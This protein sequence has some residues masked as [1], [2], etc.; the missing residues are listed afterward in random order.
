MDE[1]QY[2]IRGGVDGRERLRI[3][4]RVLAPTTRGLLERVGLGPGM[5][6]LDAGC[7]GGDVT[8]EMARMVGAAGRV[9]GIDGD[10]AKIALARAEAA[11]MSLPGLSFAV[12]TIGADCAASQLDLVYSRFVLTHLREPAAAL[13]WMVQRLRPGGLV[14]LEDIDFRGHFCHPPSDAFT[15]YV[16][17]YARVVRAHGADPDIGPRLPGLLREA[18]CGALGMHVVQPAAFAGELKL[19]AAIT[20]ENIADAVLAA[21]L[22]TRDE[23]ARLVSELHHLAVDDQ[24]VMS[25][26]RVVQAWGRRTS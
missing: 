9:L 18:G 5:S 3:L 6:C 11:E 2:V 25:L 7:G 22:A 4:A 16:E 20:L 23:L 21:D 15:R 14:V 12:A 17:L 19:L 26:P 1:R 13:G 8:V 10:A 24:T